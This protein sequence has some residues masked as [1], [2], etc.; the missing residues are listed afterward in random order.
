MLWNFSLKLIKKFSSKR[1]YWIRKI[2]SQLIEFKEGREDKFS[3]PSFYLSL[4]ENKPDAEAD[5]IIK[6]TAGINRVVIN[7]YGTEINS[8]VDF[9]VQTAAESAGKSGVVKWRFGNRRA[10]CSL[11]DD[12]ADFA[13]RVTDADERVSEWFQASFSCVIFD[14]NAAEE[15]V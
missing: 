12:V 6:R 8:V 1:E 2:L 13:A 5:V 3:L 9:Y 14:Q 4:F 7:L 10:G 15:I 11:A